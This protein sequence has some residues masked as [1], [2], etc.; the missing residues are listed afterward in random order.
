MLYGTK[1]SEVKNQ[2]KKSKYNIYMKILFCMWGKTKRYNIINDN[3]KKVL[4]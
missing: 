1:Y 4:E 3:I 2:H